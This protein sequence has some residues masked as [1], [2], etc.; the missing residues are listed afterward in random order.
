VAEV[1]HLVEPGELDPESIH[2][3]EIFV[4]RVFPCR[5]VVKHVERRTVRFR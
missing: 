2:T 5:S 4:Q 1:E 3:P